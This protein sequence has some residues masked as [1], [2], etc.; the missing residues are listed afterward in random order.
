MNQYSLFFL[1]LFIFSKNMFSQNVGIGTTMPAGKLHIKGTANT[2]QLVIDAGAAQANTHP[3]LKFRNSSG[4]D[5][6]WIH[7]DDTSNIFIGRNAGS[8]NN[9]AS[10]GKDNI[11]IG[12]C[13]GYSNSTG[14]S[15][16]GIGFNALYKNTTGVYN[17]AVGWRPLFFN[18]TGIGNSAYGEALEF[19]TTG[20]YNTGTGHGALYKNTIA[21]SNTASGAFALYNNLTGNFNSSVG[22][23]SLFSNTNGVSNV[24]I[25]VEAMRLNTTGDFNT[26][27]GVHSL[28]SNTNGSQNTSIGYD[29]LLYNKA[30]NNTA[31]GVKSLFTNTSGGHN[32]AVGHSSLF[33]NTNGYYNTALGDSTLYTN[34]TGVYNTGTGYRALLKNVT[35]NYNTALGGQALSSITE[36]N[37]STA[38][39]V[40]AL[41]YTTTGYQ[42]TA[43]GGNALATVSTGIN[44]TG[45]GVGS[46]VSSGDISYATA[47][48]A[49]AVSNADSKVRIGSTSVTVIE[50]QVGYSFPS[51]GRFK[52]NVRDDVKGLDFIMKLRPVSYNFNRLQ[53]AKH[54]KETLTEERNAALKT[55]S[56]ERMAGFV[57]QD[58][59]SAIKQSGFTSFAALHKP[60]NE[61]DN[62]SL[63][64]A[65]FVVPLVKAM[66]EQQQLLDEMKKEIIELKKLIKAAK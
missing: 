18:T 60:T 26:A 63:G 51:D 20:S 46:G 29:A 56:D 25:G 40:N 19:N 1:L 16:T 14:Y 50:G 58:V 30:S 27:V 32:T 66:Q 57:A 42:N 41:L 35:G 13:T 55:L 52:D 37:Y 3:L 65:E 11:F 44:N 62:Y 17:T 6:L 4:N 7:S 24:A 38:V 8:V 54:V 10:G 28:Y 2:S 48:G 15:N 53:Y 12:S 23:A 5:L 47:L 64:Y 39:G 9:V 59:E 21:E 33:S 36:G 31:V 45:I 49:F 22:T 61:I 43:V 34:N